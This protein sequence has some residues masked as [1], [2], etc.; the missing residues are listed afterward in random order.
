VDAVGAQGL[1]DAAADALSTSG[2]ECYPVGHVCLRF[3]LVR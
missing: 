2:D 3:P 1:D